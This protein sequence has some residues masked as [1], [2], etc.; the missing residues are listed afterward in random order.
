MCND[1]IKKSSI[2]KNLSKQKKIVIK[3]GVNFDR[4]KNLRMMKLK[5]NSQ[6][7]KN[8]NKKNEKDYKIK[9]G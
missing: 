5:T 9:K 6:I 8:S 7:K 1:E 3:L 2:L 4:K